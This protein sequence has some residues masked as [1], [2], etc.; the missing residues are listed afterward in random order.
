MMLFIQ[1]ATLFLVIF[2]GL[3]L[4]LRYI[5][6]RNITEA[7]SH[8]QE[9]DDDY[10]RKQTDVEK[11][12]ESAK[13]MS[14]E[15]TTAARTEAQKV[16]DD[17]RKETEEIKNRILQD[18]RE[19]SDQ[20]FAQAEK[21]CQ[22]LK[23]ELD[24]EIEIRS[25]EKACQLIATVLPDRVRQVIHSFYLQE[26]LESDMGL[27]LFHLPEG[28]IEVKIISA[29][30]LSDPEKENIRE[31][32]SKTLGRKIPV[33]AD[34][35]PNLIAGIM[36]TIGDIVADSSLKHRIQKAVKNASGG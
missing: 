10:T 6:A 32:L 31:K 29:L 17:A 23:N 2:V 30:P 19:K 21:S 3:V 9:L 8:L 20:M 12:L 25:G 4:F 33:E 34:T 16:T 1:I 28:N 36:V 14:A 18:A 22:V 24:R 15:M 13:R 27:E 5:L 11:Q 7:T 35:N 26:F